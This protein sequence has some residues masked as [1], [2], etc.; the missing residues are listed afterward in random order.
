VRLIRVSA[1]LL[2]IIAA[3][4]RLYRLDH[5]P[6]PMHQDELSNAYDAYSIVETG[7][8]RNGVHFP[9]V[10]RAQGAVDY[11]PAMYAWLAAVPIGVAGFSPAAARVPSAVLGIVSLVLLFLFARELVD[12][13][14]AILALAFGVFSPWHITYSRLA[15]EGAMLAGFFVIAVLY[16]W[17]SAAARDYPHRLIGATGLVIGLSANAYQTTRLIA[18]LV[19]LLVAFDI[20]RS[21]KAPRSAI[22]ILTIA[23]AIGAMPQLY[24]LITEPQHFFAR[25]MATVPTTGA[26]EPS[27]IESALHG[28]SLVFGPK[29]LFW[30]NMEDTGYLSARLLTVEL[31]FYYLGF[32]VLPGLIRRD[33]RKFGWYIY[34]V[35]A[36]AI[37]PA[38]V[39]AHSASVRVAAALLILPLWTASGVRWVAQRLSRA[40]PRIP[41]PVTYSLVAA[42]A[43]M[44]IAFT[45][46]MYFGSKTVNG[47]RSNNVLVQ[48]GERLRTLAPRYDRVFVVDSPVYAGLH[49]AAFSGMH[50]S[51]FQR[52]RKVNVDAKGWDHITS[53]GKYRFLTSGELDS[54]FQGSNQ[55]GERDLIVSRFRIEAPPPFDSVSWNN[56]RYYFT[57]AASVLL[58]K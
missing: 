55:I 2:V 28:L 5:Y 6:L 50:P 57:D 46:F 40:S 27:A 13:R 34:I 20:Y 7:A 49:V 33:R 21:A 45:A 38:V 19:L 26:K 11:R 9:I 18:P 14:Y 22:A 32:F 36:I 52:T 17:L 56:E 29:L 16:L 53:V 1:I 48:V 39:T 23:A 54:V 12:E 35:F 31:P 58:H 15:H 37:L 25:L 42:G 8:D 4:L 43:C 47:M 44:S 3:F 24:V 30:P 41:S 51:E 10:L